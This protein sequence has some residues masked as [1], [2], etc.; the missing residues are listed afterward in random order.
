MIFIPVKN[1]PLKEFI[2]LLIYSAYIKNERSV[3]GLVIA[4]PE[5]GKTQCLFEFKENNGIYMTADMTKD[6]LETLLGKFEDG[7]LKTLICPDFIK[8]FGRKLDTSKNFITL[9]NE[10]IEEGITS[11]DT[12]NTKVSFKKPVRG[13]IVCAI[14]STDFFH[15]IKYWGAIGFM[16]RIIPFSYCYTE[17]QINIIFED[18]FT[19]NVKEHLEKILKKNPKMK[20]IT[21]SKEHCK[22]IKRHI[23]AK[24]I[25]EFKKHTQEEIYGFRVQRNLQ[26]L[27]KAN[28]Y[29]N[30][31]PY[32]NEKDVLKLM[33]LSK[34]F[35]YQMCS[36]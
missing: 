10:F 20:K 15:N 35:N 16:S 31:R 8:I 19:G 32:V 30:K 26:V 28:A 29:K 22:T 36:I 25:Q 27:A 33:K 12:Y 4:K 5:S 9:V 11:I 2:E 1:E 34:W 6:G 17:T 18:I 21:I 13:N 3:S 24:L 7:Q 23:T 14:T